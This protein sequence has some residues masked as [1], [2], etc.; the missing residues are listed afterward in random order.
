MK[1]SAVF[2][3]SSFLKDC[4]RDEHSELSCDRPESKSSLVSD[5][6]L[7]Q[8]LPP[9][10]KSDTTSRRLQFSQHQAGI[11]Q[12]HSVSE[13]DSVTPESER[14]CLPVSH[15]LSAVYSNTSSDSE[16]TSHL[17]QDTREQYLP[18]TSD[19]AQNSS[20]G[21][22]SKVATPSQ[23]RKKQHSPQVKRVST[24]HTSPKQ[25]KK[26]SPN[27]EKKTRTV[28]KIPTLCS[29]TPKGPTS[30]TTTSRA[31]LR[32]S[33]EYQTQKS[34]P[35]GKESERVKL[36]P[37]RSKSEAK[38]VVEEVFEVRLDLCDLMI[39]HTDCVLTI[40]YQLQKEYSHFCLKITCG[41]EIIWGRKLIYIRTVSDKKK[42]YQQL[43]LIIDGI[44]DVY[45]HLIEEEIDIV[46]YGVYYH[47][48]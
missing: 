11:E 19:Q 2:C 31:R 32:K 28:S 3:Q 30:S 37:K 41:D 48:Q 47:Q 17:G 35:A 45:P 26:S 21:S 38:A 33:S 36:K 40:I 1:E 4:C 8:Q 7:H 9:V 18:E 43:K 10:E 14:E 34:A 6:F 44:R 20:A 12:S 39:S 42:L 23:G 25:Q 24:D 29:K 13:N 46:I 22:K 5:S 27:T 16:T 15:S